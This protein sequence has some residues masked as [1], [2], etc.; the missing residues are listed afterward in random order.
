M[1]RYGWRAHIARDYRYPTPDALM[2][3]V[4]S[5]PVSPSWSSSPE[6]RNRRNHRWRS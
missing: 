3:Q 4:L 1:V 5:N 2:S 6:A